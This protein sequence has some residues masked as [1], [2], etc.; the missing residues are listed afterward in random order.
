MSIAFPNHHLNSVILYTVIFRSLLKVLDNLQ[1]G[2]HHELKLLAENFLT[3]SLLHND[4]PRIINPILMK[5]L[6][7]NTARVSI[8]HVNIQDA[9]AQSD[10]SSQDNNKLQDVQAKKVYAVSSVN[11]NIMYHI[12]DSPSLK[13]TKRKWFTFSKSGKKFATAVNM[14]TSI[15][16]DSNIV[17][18]KNKDFKGV[19]VS[20]KLEKGIKNVKLIINPLSSKEVYPNG[21]NGFYSKLETP[22]SFESLSSSNESVHY[23]F[24]DSIGKIYPHKNGYDR[25]SGFDSLKHKSHPELT[26][27]AN[28]G[29]EFTTKSLLES[30]EPISD[31]IKA[32][33]VN[34]TILK[35][36]KSHS[37][38]EKM[39]VDKNSDMENNL[40]QSWSYCISDS[41]NLH[42]NC[43]LELSK[44]AEDF[45]RGKNEEYAVVTD[46]LNFIIDKVCSH[47][48]EGPPQR[49]T[50]LDLKTKMNQYS[51]NVVLFPIHSHLCL[52]Y[53]LFDSNQVLYAVQI[54]KNCIV[55]TP[56]LFIKCLATSGMKNLKN[57]EILYLLARHRKSLLGYG[58]AGELSNE[59]LNFYRGYMF[60]DVIILICLN[61]TRTFYPFLNDPLL[62]PE[63]IKN[64]LKIQLDS[65]EILDSIIKNLKVLTEEN[66]KGF[67]SYIADLLVKCKLQKILLNCLLTSVRSSDEDVTFADELLAF[68]EFQFCDKN[69]KV[70]EHVEA[71][72]IQILR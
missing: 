9:D 35:I 24:D 8:K 58:F 55:S 47:A 6:A 12:T 26:N 33:A 18:R 65:L 11:G 50:E 38:D 66:S 32:E 60:L 30:I 31:G 28:Y 54:L 52:Y 15:T 53:D 49:P 71:F 3:H 29:K 2:Q 14:T 20:P 19:N 34:D 10:V 46:I 44:S 13:P 48:S 23:S 16:E 43:E 57:S 45:F 25:D 22:S 67:S 39:G 63:E 62:T 40:V 5:L 4:I 41:A 56:Q 1:N 64:N 36:T 51:K 37:F 17:T 72:Q 27:V 61:F 7:S 21:L 59:H 69:N 70:G 42:G 68:N